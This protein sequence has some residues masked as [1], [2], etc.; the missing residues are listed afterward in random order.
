MKS[1][2]VKIRVTSCSIKTEILMDLLKKHPERLNL[3]L[4]ECYNVRQY[5]RLMRQSVKN[6]EM[7]KTNSL[8]NC[9]VYKM[10]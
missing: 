4:P 3:D 10:F 8:R 1:V 9:S 5:Q 6:L 7:C 2:F